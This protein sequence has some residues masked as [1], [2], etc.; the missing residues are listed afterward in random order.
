MLRQI[1]GNKFPGQFE[2][3]KRSRYLEAADMT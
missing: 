2:Y 3:L 1:T